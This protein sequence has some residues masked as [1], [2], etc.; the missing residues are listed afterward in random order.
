MKWSLQHLVCTFLWHLPL[1]PVRYYG[2]NVVVFSY[3][4]TLTL[5]YYTRDAGNTYEMKETLLTFHDY[6]YT[7]VIDTNT[8]W[9]RAPSDLIQVIQPPRNYALVKSHG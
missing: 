2:T 6:S 9:V 8:Y 5:M 4:Y 3:M 1:L 7:I